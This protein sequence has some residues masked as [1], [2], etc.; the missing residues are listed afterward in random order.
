MTG[1][2]NSETKSEKDRAARQKSLR[3]AAATVIVLLVI[4]IGF[5]FFSQAAFL[6]FRLSVLLKLGAG[7]LAT[8]LLAAGLMA[9]AFYSDDS[10]HD[11]DASNKF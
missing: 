8:I 10:G 4:V 1:S 11:E 2:H 6:D 5:V 7:V 9:A 3:G